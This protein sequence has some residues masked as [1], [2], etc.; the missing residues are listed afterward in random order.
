MQVFAPLARRLG[1]YE[2]KEE[3]EE[4]SFRYAHPEQYAGIKRRLD[5][6]AAQQGPSVL[7][8]RQF[9]FLNRLGTT[10]TIIRS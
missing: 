7:Q 6:L 4:L 3:L 9:L 2:I 5:E 1:L 10:Y 8:V